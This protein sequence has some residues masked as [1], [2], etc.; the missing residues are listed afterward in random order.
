MEVKI[1]NRLIF[2]RLINVNISNF[3]TQNVIDMKYMFCN[4]YEL[5]SIDV[6]N[7]NTENVED[8]NYMFNGCNN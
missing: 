8:M 6:S 3:K 1:C 4:D 2:L 7:F 5:T